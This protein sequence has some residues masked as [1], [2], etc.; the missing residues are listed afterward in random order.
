MT[1]RFG[2]R[3]NPVTGQ[4]QFHTGVDL[5]APVGTPVVAP[6]AGR[7]VRVDVAGVGRGE[8][9]GNAVHLVTGG[10]LRWAF[11]HLSR[12]DVALGQAVRQAQRL[13]RV[14]AT[15]RATGPHLH[16]QVTWQGQPIDPV[17]LYPPGTFT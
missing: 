3:T 9:N 11:L 12:V 17:G 7:V 10:G 15:G 5:A 6:A 13:G 8:V 16:L 14:G 2:W 1:S 4:R